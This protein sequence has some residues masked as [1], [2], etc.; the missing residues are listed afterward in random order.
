MHVSVGVPQGSQPRKIAQGGT[1]SG[2]AGFME[3]ENPSTSQ[4]VNFYEFSVDGIGRYA[5]YQYLPN[6]Y[7]QPA[8]AYY[9]AGRIATFN[10]EANKLKD[11]LTSDMSPDDIDKK[12]YAFAQRNSYL[13]QLSIQTESGEKFYNLEETGSHFFSKKEMTRLETNLKYSDRQILNKPYQGR[14]FCT[15][16]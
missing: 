6:D 9:D 12:V 16:L 8:S 15:I 3:A 11:T 13:V 5:I 4:H 2:R 7:H 14:L 1:T 10:D